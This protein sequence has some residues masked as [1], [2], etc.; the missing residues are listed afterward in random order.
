MVWRA[1][2]L[3]DDTCPL[4]LAGQ[5]FYSPY[6]L[7]ASR[8]RTLGLCKHFWQQPIRHFQPLNVVYTL[9]ARNLDN[10][11]VCPENATI[12][13]VSVSGSCGTSPRFYFSGM[14]R[15]PLPVHSFWQYRFLS[16][17]WHIQRA[18]LVSILLG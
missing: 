8:S 11:L 2:P 4:F 9:V 15:E 7:D 17:F 3:S 10:S 16:V 12:R 5:R 18:V 1:N 13:G 14:W 6:L